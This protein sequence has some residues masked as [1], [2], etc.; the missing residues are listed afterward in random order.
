MQLP[1]QFLFLLV[2]F[3]V[4]SMKDVTNLEIVQEILR[5]ILISVL[6]FPFL[7]RIDPR[8]RR[9]KVPVRTP[10][11][12]LGQ[13]SHRTNQG[14]VLRVPHWREDREASGARRQGHDHRLL[15]ESHGLRRCD[16]VR[17]PCSRRG[18]VPVQWRLPVRHLPVDARSC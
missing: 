14:K 18:I 17:Q 8:R 2:F 10:R 13:H 6:F 9:T 1:L 11:P 12:P 16:S 3:V 7:D 15:A 5:I 4:V